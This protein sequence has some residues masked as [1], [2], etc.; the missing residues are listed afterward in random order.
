MHENIEKTVSSLLSTF[1]KL[2]DTIGAATEFD[3]QFVEELQLE[4]VFEVGSL[5]VELNEIHEKDKARFIV[6]LVQQYNL[7]KER[8]D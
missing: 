2:F 3:E 7:A 4:K 8:H 1:Y 5:L 6:L